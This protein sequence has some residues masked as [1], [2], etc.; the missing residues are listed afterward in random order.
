MRKGERYIRHQYAVRAQG[1]EG[2]EKKVSERPIEE[3][4]Y[5]KAKKGAGNERGGK[6]VKLSQS[7]P[8]LKKREKRLGR[9]IIRFVIPNQPLA[10]IG[11]ES[12]E[13]RQRRRNQRKSAMR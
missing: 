7:E 10:E 5:R 11:Q 3:R 1:T 9:P 12:I 13:R 6:I 4:G 8:N 2:Q